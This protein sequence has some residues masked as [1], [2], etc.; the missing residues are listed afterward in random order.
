MILLVSIQR[1][2]GVTGKG[3]KTCHGLPLTAKS[4]GWPCHSLWPGNGLRRD[5]GHSAFGRRWHIPEP[6]WLAAFWASTLPAS[7]RVAA[8]A[9]A[10]R[11]QGETVPVNTAS[12][13][14]AG[15]A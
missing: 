14:A 6:R 13:A 8:S 12:E 7:T 3:R 11:G 15:T 1:P 2:P 9:E 10:R 5:A 4:M